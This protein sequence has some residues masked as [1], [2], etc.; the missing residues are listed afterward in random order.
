M[1]NN[2]QLF[3]GTA[4]WS[5]KDWNGTV[6]PQIKPR[7]F[8]PLE[9]LSEKF[10][11]VEV[12][13]TFYRIP[14]IKLC[15]G[16]IKKTENLQNFGFWIKINQNCTHKYT[17]FKSEVDAFISALQPLIKER[18]LFGLLA[19]FPYS[20]KLNEKNFHYLV[21]IIKIFKHYNLAIEFRHNSWNRND[22]IENFKNSGIIWTNID[23]PL[24]SLSLPITSI[25]TNIDTAYF[26]LHGR[27][28]EH[29]F[30]NSGRDAR[31]NYNYDLKELTE[32]SVEIIKLKK[33]AKRIFISGNNHYKGAAVKNLIELKNILESQPAETYILEK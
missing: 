5:Y 1:L 17:L 3:Y 12:N 24:I 9:F 7:N 14:T 21:N 26:R 33:L 16:W 22:I 27:N 28:R 13:T 10:N 15:E 25:V 30:A 29:W 8:N 32:I 20:F 18:K 11:F 4:G 31:Y 19:Q 23:Q 2:P 6:Y